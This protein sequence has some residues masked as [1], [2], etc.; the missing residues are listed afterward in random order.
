[1]IRQDLRAAK[2]RSTEIMQPGDIPETWWLEADVLR[3]QSRTS[4]MELRFGDVTVSEYSPYSQA[5]RI[6]VRTHLAAQ[7]LFR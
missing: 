5:A 1:M 7:G 2:I 3:L 4:N 6:R